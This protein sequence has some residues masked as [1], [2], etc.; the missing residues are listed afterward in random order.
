MCPETLLWPA[1]HPC[2][3]CGSLPRTGRFSAIGS[4]MNDPNSAQPGAFRPALVAQ[5]VEE[6]ECL[7]DD[8]SAKLR[9]LDVIL[10]SLETAA[11][12]P[13]RMLLT[14]HE[15]AVQL[16]VGDTTLHALIRTGALRSVKIGSA[17]RVP[18]EALAEFVASL[19]DS[20]AVET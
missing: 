17:R 19:Q 10:R 3:W 13:P 5:V 16:G 12:G 4:E 6:I 8:V 14:V 1:T 11:T 7:V 9:E 20:G 15:A 2:N 18:V